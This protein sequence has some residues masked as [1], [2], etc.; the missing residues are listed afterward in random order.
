[1]EL[2]LL[3]YD[4][5]FSKKP[6]VQLEVVEDYKLLFSLSDNLL[7]VNDISR[8]NFPMIH[9]AAKTKGATA[10]AMNVQKTQSL[11]GE[12]A[13]WLLDEFNQQ[14]FSYRSNHTRRSSLCCSKEKTATL[15]LEKG[16]TESLRTWYRS[17]WRAESCRMDW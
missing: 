12:F 2:Q 1:M 15:L 8:H 10:F 6:I 5:N 3:Q 16:R 7:S 14:F 9:L 4:K 13:Q 11:T 17:N